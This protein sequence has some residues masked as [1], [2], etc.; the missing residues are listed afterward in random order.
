[1][2]LPIDQMLRDA[3]RAWELRG[4]MSPDTLLGDLS[5]HVRALAEQCERLTRERDAYLAM[6]T[7]ESPGGLWY[8]ATGR[9]DPFVVSWTAMELDGPWHDRNEAV[10]AVR[11]LAGLDAAP[12]EG[13]STMSDD[14][15]KPLIERDEAFR[16]AERAGPEAAFAEKCREDWEDWEA[17]NW[18]IGPYCR[19]CGNRDREKFA[20]VDNYAN[21]TRWRCKT[22]GHEFHTGPREPGE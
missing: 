9:M 20:C 14:D 13:A 19:E 16:R 3:G 17:E 22:C 18:G 4:M 11:R 2:N 5:C 8:A 15:Q 7:P 6:L 21:G 1:V 10:A 12:A